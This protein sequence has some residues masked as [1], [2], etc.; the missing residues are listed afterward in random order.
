MDKNQTQTIVA[1][2]FYEEASSSDRMRKNSAASWINGLCDVVI[3][4]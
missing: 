4:I 1:S 2:E 3:Q